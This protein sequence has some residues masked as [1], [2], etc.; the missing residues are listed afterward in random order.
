M[1]NVKTL[2]IR[3]ANEIRQ[4]DLRFFRGAV[5]AAVGQSDSTLFHNH[6]G[7]GFRY[8]YPL[9]Q[10]KRIHKKAAIVCVG[11]G[12]DEIGAFFSRSDFRLQLGNQAEQLFEIEMVTP[13][14]TVVQTWNDGF[15][16]YINNW[17][18]LNKE[19]YQSYQQLEG[20]ADRAQMLER[21]LTGN[22]L[23]ACKGFGITIEGHIENKIL[24][25]DAPHP[26]IYKG[27]SWTNFD[28]VVRSNVSL[29]DYIGLGKGASLGHGIITS[30]KS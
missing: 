8:R 4:Q 29:P 30:R 15:V 21:I 3:F 13:H 17:L 28:A 24:Q 19:N 22:I 23:S 9:I 18:P 26:S 11:E 12:C 1:N 6:D 27:V 25:L 5:I 7:E 20:I 2:I 14:R 16:Y 10:Y